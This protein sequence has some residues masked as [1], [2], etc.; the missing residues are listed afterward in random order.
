MA[1]ARGKYGS[2]RSSAPPSPS[3]LNETVFIEPLRDSQICP[4]K[5]VGRCKVG[6]DQRTKRTGEQLGMGMLFPHLL[7]CMK[8][9][10]GHARSHDALAGDTMGE[11][12]RSFEQQRGPPCVMQAALD[13]ARRQLSYAASRARK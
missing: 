8:P 9:R 1:T 3:R 4:G 5:W 12:H 11:L 2:A 6:N 13:S 10:N 7:D